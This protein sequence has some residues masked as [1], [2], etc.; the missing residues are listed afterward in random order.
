MKNKINL[1]TTDIDNT[2]FDWVAYYVNSFGALLKS[3]EQTIGVP[4]QTLAAESKVVFEANGS[5]EFPFLIQEL[6]SVIEYYGADIDGMLSQAVVPG[7]D[8]FLEVAESYFQPYESVPE[9]LAEFR[10]THPGVPMVALT[11]APR[12]VAM[13]KMNKLGLLSYFDAIYDSQIPRFPRALA[14]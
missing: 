5:I 6:P 7:R 1:F 11:D 3:V 10:K 2:L 8:A 13:W 12:Y 14:A 4:Y 9:T